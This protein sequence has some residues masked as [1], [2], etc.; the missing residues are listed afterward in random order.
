MHEVEMI[1]TKAEYLR[2]LVIRRDNI[3]DLVCT[4]PLFAALRAR[5]PHAQIAALV[6]SYNAAVLEGNPDIDAVHVYTKLKHR[7]PG[8]SRLRIVLGRLRMLAR[9]RS[10]P[11]DFVVLAKAGFDRQGV[12]FA[13][14]LK[15][16]HVIG[17]TEPGPRLR[18]SSPFQCREA[19]IPL[20][21]RSRSCSF[22]RRRWTYRMRAVRC[23]FIRPG[24]AWKLGARGFPRSLRTAADY[25]SACTSARARPRGTGLSRIGSSSSPACA[26]RQIPASSSCGPRGPR[27]TPVTPAM[28][29]RLKKS[30]G[31]PAA[32]TFCRLPLPHFRTSSRSWRYATPLSAPMAALRT[33]QRP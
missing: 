2:I 26:P 14:Q 5:Y 4:T 12:G 17:F 30:S 22:S 6:N 11:F 8:E 15:R 16:R 19:S 10:E 33:S 13:R 27:M 32:R 9:L 28:T 24:T 25:G 1:A 23:A 18:Q 21:T 20:C 29:R 7:L 31:K 3:G